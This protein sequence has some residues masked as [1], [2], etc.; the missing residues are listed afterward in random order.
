MKNSDYMGKRGKRIAVFGFGKTGRA[1]LDFLLEQKQYK[2][3]ALYL[4]NDSPIEAPEDRRSKRDYEIRGVTFII[5]P[6]RFGELEAMDLILLSPG[7]DGR[8]E[9]FHRLRQKGITI[10]AEIEFAFNFIKAPIIAVT[11]TNGKSTTVSLIH[12]FLSKNGINSFLTGN[13]GT[14]L[15]SEVGRITNR[16]VLVVEVSSFQLEEIVDFKPYIAL[17]LNVTPDHLDRY[18]NMGDY[19]DA[20]L[21]IGKNQ[22]NSDY[23]ILNDDDPLLRENRESMGAARRVWFSRFQQDFEVGA[24]IID[25]HIH[26]KLEE[27]DEKISLRKNPLRG[28]HNLENLLASVTAA[29]LMGVS[30]EG[31]ETSMGDFK[32]LPHRMESVGKIRDVEFINDSKA[33]NVD[34]TLKSINSMDRRLV[35]ILGGKDKGS[36]FT[37]LRDSLEEKADHVLLVGDAAFTI[38]HQLNDIEKKFSFAAD[39]SEA[40]AKGYQWLK[41]KGGVVLLAPGCASFDMFKNFEHR[42]EVFKEEV[43]KLRS[44]EEGVTNG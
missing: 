6:E 43:L 38:Y 8:T 40:V 27:I 4:F 9:R 26:I 39:L 3:K 18:K 15:I 28:L 12:H 5:G 32:G 34:A 22:E 7:V 14:P 1:L 25:H 30:G 11:G 10:I 21:N 37:I 44:K 41:E 23:I 17:I 36:D 16:S 33:T 42:G 29:R 31:I 24:C 2:T 19:F 13:I 20:K 35:L